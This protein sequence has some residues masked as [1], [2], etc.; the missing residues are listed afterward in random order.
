ML[1]FV[2]FLE[3]KYKT[4]ITRMQLKKKPTQTNSNSSSTIK[5]QQYVFHLVI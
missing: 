1:G 5:T 3:K 4:S 2:T